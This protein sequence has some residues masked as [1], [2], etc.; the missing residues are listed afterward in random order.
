[1]TIGRQI[2]SEPLRL[3]SGDF[4]AARIVVT[5]GGDHN[6]DGTVE[7][8]GNPAPLNVSGYTFLSQI[9][10]SKRADVVLATIAVDATNAA[11]GILILSLTP[12]QTRAL[13]PPS[14]GKDQVAAF[15]DFQ[16]TPP[17]VD[18]PITWW[19]GP[20]TIDMDVSRL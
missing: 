3:R 10:A 17:A 20:V 6:R 1:M 11:T 16:G 18:E 15:Y 5:D 14:S 9:R 7:D 2:P 19:E 4:W 8:P 13:N 12:A